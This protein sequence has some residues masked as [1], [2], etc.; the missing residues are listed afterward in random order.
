M[1][2]LP[3]IDG[4]FLLTESHHSPRHVAG[5]QI[6]RLPKG[7]GSAWL[8][9]L[10]NEMRQA[11]PGFPFNQKLRD[12]IGLQ[13]VLEKDDHF[14]IDYHVR[15]TVL[16]RPGNDEQLLDVVARLHANLLDRER[17][18][19]EFHL[20][21]G[22]SQRRFALYIKVHHALGDGVT[23]SRWTL[24]SLSTSARE[25]NSRPIWARDEKPGGFEDPDISYA[26][27]LVDGIKYIGGGI[28]T[29]FDLST[30]TAKIVQR[31]FFDRDSQVALP[32]SAPRTSINVPTGAARSITMA[33]YPL[34]Q[35]RAIGKSRG[36]TIN[37]V[38]MTLCDM[39]LSRYFEEHG[40]VP[41]GPLVAYMPV[42]IR[43]ED[44]QGDGNFISL[45]QVKLASS[46]GDA[47]ST[48]RE[49]QASLA[50]AREVYSGASRSAVQYYGLM[51]ALLAH[52]Q[53]ALKLDEINAQVTNLVISN[54]PGPKKPLYLKGAELLGI[55][56]VSTLPPLTALN[57]TAV[58]Y[59]DT[60]NF[61]LIAARSSIP[62]LALLT[63][64]LDD[65]FGELAEA[66]AISM[67]S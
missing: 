54:V 67:D 57:V 58:S 49:V 15:H 33:S 2:K 9:S 14:D 56:P 8:R 43:T 3:L 11:N 23:A 50:S 5:L 39:A 40:D 38:V 24:E 41:E 22:L 62:D 18:L 26:Q 6:F 10:L 19:W 34:E 29:A 16:P 44:D 64:Y 17:P 59:V 65:A 12:Q 21:E 4:G 31:R 27:M 28:K 42:N 48:L 7:K 52:F 37:D 47:L 66:V 32:L 30:L 51:V 36:A 61:G 1:T 20:I 13:Y 46:H 53:E 35:M 45:L 60:L 63:T 55:F 25:M